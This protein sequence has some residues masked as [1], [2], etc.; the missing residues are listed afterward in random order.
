L[1][2]EI[3]EVVQLLLIGVKQSSIKECLL[4]NQGKLDYGFNLIHSFDSDVGF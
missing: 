3:E 2:E 4:C 1:D